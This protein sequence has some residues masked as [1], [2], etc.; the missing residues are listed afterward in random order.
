MSSIGKVGM[1]AFDISKM[2]NEGVI[3]PLCL[4]DGKE[5]HEFLL[6][7]GA[8]SKLF[9]LELSSGNKRLLEIA[10]QLKE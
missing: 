4:P 5:T 7:L 3:L 2:S 9:N 10:K 6:I 8:D 1:E